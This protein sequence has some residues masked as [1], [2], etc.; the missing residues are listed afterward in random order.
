MTT[1]FCLL[2]CA[3]T[4][5][6]QEFRR[7]KM[8]IFRLPRLLQK[9][10]STVYHWP[11]IET[12][13]EE[14]SRMFT[15]EGRLEYYR[16]LQDM[17]VEYLSECNNFMS[18]N[19][20]LGAGLDKPNAHRLLELV[21]H[22]IPT[23][24]HARNCTEMVLESLHQ[25]FKKW[26]P[27]STHQN[28]HISAVERALSCD[29]AG[30]VYTL[31]RIWESGTSRERACCEVGL[32][33]LLVGEEMMLMDESEEKVSDLKACFA[34]Q[35][36]LA[37]KDPVLGMMGK[38]S[39]IP[40]T[41]ARRGAWCVNSRDKFKLGEGPK[42]E[43]Y[44]RKGRAILQRHY[45]LRSGYNTTAVSEFR[46]AR[47]VH[48]NIY[49]SKRNAYVF[50][51]ITEGTVVSCPT[52]RTEDIVSRDDMGRGTLRKYAVVTVTS[53]PDDKLWAITVPMQDV[54]YEGE[55]GMK[56]RPNECVLLELSRSVRRAGTCH[57]CN[58]S[59]KL[60][61][62]KLQVEHDEG[63]LD[64]GLYEVWTRENNY[65]PYMG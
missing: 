58:S 9:I 12:D 35:L 18:T 29:W 13:G 61:P 55:Q 7:T 59:C 32:R 52:E 38:N 34:R 53:A 33:R 10:M 5:F 50:N 17:A 19:N 57:I 24:G 45:N 40:L 21:F 3:A 64:G 62:R 39:H 44:A 41:S 23:F 28:C 27:K 43:L 15:T 16:K 8:R 26:L 37:L 47:Y 65:P 14:H 11:C 4:Q 42:H 48:S 6:D 54:N 46:S 2:L 51:E 49:G 36:R 22:T 30:R 20:L 60:H 63:I 25:V 1:Y 56:I 31:F